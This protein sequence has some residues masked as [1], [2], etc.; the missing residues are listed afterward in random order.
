MK[1]YTYILIVISFLYSCNNTTQS[2][3][4]TQTNETDLKNSVN[5]GANSDEK[6]HQYLTIEGNDIWVR[7]ISKTGKVIMKLN[8]GNK[9]IILEKGEEQNINGFIDNWY[10]IEFNEKQGWVFG[11][12]TS[13]KS[14]KNE[15]EED[16]NKKLQD[17]YTKIIEIIQSGKTEKLNSF[18]YDKKMIII[19]TNPGV[20]TVGHFHKNLK[21]LHYLHNNIKNCK[22][23]F[24]I[25]PK[26]QM[27]NETW[28]KSGCFAENIKSDNGG[29]YKIFKSTEKEA[30]GKFSKKEFQKV[31]LF[32]QISSIRII[33]T[34]IITRFY[35]TYKNGK[36]LLLA[37]DNSDFSA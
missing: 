20:Y 10:K 11:S 3:N 7:E 18:F 21:A 23:K 33:D 13:V 9:C 1:K 35:F 26:F 15:T 32:G 8:T 17:T 36:W 4:K 30:L 34:K 24:E 19:I 16:K 2:N 12:Q 22:L 5:N 29:F 28:S 14:R 27:E 25:W 37:V 31:K 6:K